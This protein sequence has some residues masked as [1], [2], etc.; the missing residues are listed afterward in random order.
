MLSAIVAS[1][2]DWASSKDSG[3]RA[4]SLSSFMTAMKLARYSGLATGYGSGGR[5]CALDGFADMQLAS[6]S[7]PPSETCEI[8]VR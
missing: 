7:R 5:R 6:A 4:S 1:H 3:T 2:S 8:R